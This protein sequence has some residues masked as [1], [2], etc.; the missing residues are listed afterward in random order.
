MA[1]V[2]LVTGMALGLQK[3]HCLSPRVLF[4]NKWRKKIEGQL[5]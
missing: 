5:P 4:W 1:G 3:L 2:G